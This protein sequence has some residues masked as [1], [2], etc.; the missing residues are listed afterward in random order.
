[1][2]PNML[3]PY[4]IGVGF[5]GFTAST[6]A[7][8]Q[9]YWDVYSAEQRWKEICCN[10]KKLI[11]Y[12]DSMN[13]ELG[14]TKDRVSKL[15]ADFQKFLESGYF[16]YYA[17]QIEQWILDNTSWIFERFCKMVFFGLTD[18]GYFCAYVPDSWK[19]ITFDTG[20]NYGT[21]TYGRL[22]LRYDTDGSGV[23]DNTEY[24]TPGS[25]EE[26]NELKE[27]V[28]KLQQTVYTALSKER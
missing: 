1:M 18:D 26:L 16:D 8:P 2:P 23:I 24:G 12:A 21:Y 19:E 6:P 15:E 10:L 4:G 7:I 13:I 28:A 25:V 3:K 9:M 20:M 22:I 5:A 14:V 11:E 17:K 27:K